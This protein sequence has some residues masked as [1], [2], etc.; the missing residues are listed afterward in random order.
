MSG[1]PDGTPA[2]GGDGPVL[3]ATEISTAVA[4]GYSPVADTPSPIVT[5]ATEKRATPDPFKVGTEH[6][7]I[8][9]TPRPRRVRAALVSLGLSVDEQPIP[10]PFV[11]PGGYRE[12]PRP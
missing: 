6:W 1:R 11:D 2:K 9:W 7:A 8:F 3:M 10:R 12:P 5:A 4:T